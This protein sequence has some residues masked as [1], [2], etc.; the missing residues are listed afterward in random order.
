MNSYT[1][2]MIG[3]GIGVVTDW[4]EPT[5]NSLLARTFLR[6]RIAININQPLPT[7]IW[8][9]R[10][11]LPKVWVQLRYER[12]QDC[13]CLNC[14]NQEG[15][16]LNKEN[17]AQQAE[18]K[19]SSDEATSPAPM[20]IIAGDKKQQTREINQGPRKIRDLIKDLKGKGRR[21]EIQKARNTEHEKKKEK[22]NEEE[23][24]SKHINEDTAKGKE[25][26]Y[27][28]ENE[29]KTMGGQANTMGEGRAYFVEL[30]HEEDEENEGKIMEYEN[31]LA[32]EITN[33]LNIKRQR[34]DTEVLMIT[35]KEEEENQVEQRGIIFNKKIKTAEEALESSLAFIKWR[36]EAKYYAEEVEEAGHIKPHQAP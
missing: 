13:Y 7:G 24:R 31:K 9:N 25:I 2:K 27:I 30:A 34:E 10:E 8:L 20:E 4:E 6:A 3:N 1:A 14:D 5:K 11:K 26:I 23:G 12:L 29:E 28:E 15:K 17:Q 35:D 21:K 22:P 18:G 19:Q 16:Q 36:A 33:K 32:L